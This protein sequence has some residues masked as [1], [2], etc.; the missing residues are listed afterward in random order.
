MEILI[1]NYYETLALVALL[2]IIIDII[3]S[4][5]YPTHIAY[6]L[7]TLFCTLKIKAPLVTSM[8]LAVIIWFAFITFHYM[9][10]RKQLEKIHDK[11]ISP[12]KHVG[13]IERVIGMNGKIKKIEGELFIEVEKE[14][15]QF[16]SVILKEIKEGESHKIINV[17]SHKLII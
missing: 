7:L 16:E 9:V 13:G 6:V 17:K 11:I 15:Y 10:W 4:F 8:L 3:L 12:R 2:L 14:V 5:E 1:T